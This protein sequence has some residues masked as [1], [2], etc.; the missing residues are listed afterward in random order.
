MATNTFKAVRKTNPGAA[1]EKIVI[2]PIGLIGPITPSGSRLL[3]PLDD[4][5][6]TKESYVTPVIRLGAGYC[7]SM[8]PRIIRILNPDSICVIRGAL[9]LVRTH[10]VGQ[11]SLS[12]CFLIDKTRRLIYKV[13]HWPFVSL[14]NFRPVRP[15]ALN[16]LRTVRVVP[17]RDVSRLWYAATDSP[18][19]FRR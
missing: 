12:P 10:T 14:N 1:P 7:T 6:A 11:S 8:E 18:R 17:R 19:Y 15:H 5:L 16:N 13:R 2:G 3:T 4:V 9:S